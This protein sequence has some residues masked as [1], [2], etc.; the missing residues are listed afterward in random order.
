[1]L[2][3]VDACEAKRGCGAAA[4][5]EVIISSSLDIVMVTVSSF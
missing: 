4:L 3:L 1:M 2:H 5:L